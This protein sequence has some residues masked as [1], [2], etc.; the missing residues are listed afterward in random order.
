MIHLM[1]DKRP[2]SDIGQIMLIIIADEDIIR[3]K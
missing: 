2:R 3:K 1:L